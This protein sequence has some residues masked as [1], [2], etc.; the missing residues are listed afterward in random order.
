MINLYFRDANLSGNRKNH[1]SAVE[2]AGVDPGAAKLM[3]PGTQ[4]PAK[5]GKPW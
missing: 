2:E 5:L 1:R 3:R 4:A